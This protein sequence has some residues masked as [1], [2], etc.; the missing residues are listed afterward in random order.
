[1]IQ[2][3]KSSVE[4]MRTARVS[5]TTCPTLLFARRVVAQAFH[6][7]LECKDGK[8]TVDAWRA[9]QW[10]TANTDWTIHGQVIPPAE[11]R[12]EFNGTFEW[13]CRWLGESPEEVRLY[14]LSPL[15]GMEPTGGIDAIVKAWDLAREEFLAAGA[16]E[17]SGQLCLF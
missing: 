15:R 7:A 14:G 12:E 11:V 4:N 2:S 3:N 13:A 10:L 17:R 1:M 9:Y 6:D 8:P 16:V 5:V